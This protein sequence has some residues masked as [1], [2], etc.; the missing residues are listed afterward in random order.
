M[1]EITYGGKSLADIHKE[2]IRDN[3]IFV[4]MRVKEIC[5]PDKTFY[6]TNKKEKAIRDNIKFIG[7]DEHG[8]KKI[9]NQSMKAYYPE[10]RDDNTCDQS[11]LALKEVFDGTEIFKWKPSNDTPKYSKNDIFID[12]NFFKATRQQDNEVMFSNMLYYYFLNYAE[13]TKAFLEKVCNIKISNDFTVDREKDRMDI[14]IIDDK[15][16]IIFEN[17]I[18]SAINGVHTQTEDQK[19]NAKKDSKSKTNYEYK[20]GFRAEEG[21]Y[22]SQLSVYYGKA[23]EQN[24]RD[25]KRRT[26]TGFVL[27]PN[28]NGFDQEELGKYLYGDK[29]K[30]VA[31]S[32]IREFFKNN[33]KLTNGDKYID[34]FI[35]AMYK[36]T[37]PTDNEHRNELLQRL[38]Y[39]IDSSK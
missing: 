14:R 8:G 30:Y 3:E 22:I 39:R 26:I 17:K 35:N 7:D 12:N 11:Y 38:K 6:L 13:F 16:Y 9:A 28:Y 34:D 36:H 27:A 18:K 31:Y 1:K 29:Y 33:K 23:E 21:K 5:L 4:S 15:Y 37:T 2:N 24:Q 10:K 20:D 19:N 25:K 32:E